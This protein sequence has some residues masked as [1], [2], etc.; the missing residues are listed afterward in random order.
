MPT[1]TE[2]LVA[3]MKEWRSADPDGPVDRNAIAQNVG[4]YLCNYK[5]DELMEAI[6]LLEEKLNINAW[7]S[8]WVEKLKYIIQHYQEKTSDAIRKLEGA[9]TDFVIDVRALQAMV[10]TALMATT[11]HEKD[12]RLRGLIDFLSNRIQDMERSY[13]NLLSCFYDYQNYRFKSLYPIRN[14]LDK[15][16]QAEYENEILRKKLGELP[17]EK[18]DTEDW[19]LPF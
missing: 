17:K 19:D 13:G 2:E 6:L 18:S 4:E 11:H 12:A 8:T 7:S 5:F 3:M 10:S 9:Q 15:W 16:R 14:I 1:N